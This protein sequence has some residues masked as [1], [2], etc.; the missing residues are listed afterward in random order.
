MRARTNKNRF[1]N[2]INFDVDA[3]KLRTVRDR[4]GNYIHANRLNTTFGNY[5]LAQGP[6]E[7]TLVDW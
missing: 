1:A 2:F 4:D 6:M 7:D 5:V 3:V